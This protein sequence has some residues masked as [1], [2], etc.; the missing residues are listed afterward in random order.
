M[1]TEKAMKPEK[2]IFISLM[3]PQFYLELMIL[4]KQSSFLT[5]Q[6]QK[7]DG[8][9]IRLTNHLLSF[10]KP[11]EKVGI[12]FHINSC[13]LLPGADP[14]AASGGVGLSKPWCG[15]SFTEIWPGP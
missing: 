9:E 3:L 5:M 2:T 14:T 11:C 12:F 6:K 7:N 1:I 15:R 13:Q 8:S 10:V 4:T